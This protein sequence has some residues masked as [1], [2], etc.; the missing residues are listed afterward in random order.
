MLSYNAVSSARLAYVNVGIRDD[1]LR[2][3]QVST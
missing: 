3:S 1:H 2:T